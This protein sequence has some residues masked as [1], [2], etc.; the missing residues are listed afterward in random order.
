MKKYII[1]IDTGGT[2][3]DAVVMEKE[4]GRIIQISKTPTTHHLLSQGIARALKDI[5]DLSNITPQAIEKVAISSTLATN[6]VV[7]K[8]GARVAVLVIGYV[9]HFKLPVQA[10]LFIKGGHTITGAEEE[11]LDLDYLVSLLGN[12]EDEVDAFG[13]CSSMSFKNPAH[14]LVTEKA[15]GMIAP[16]PVF[17]SHRI[18]QQAG[19]QERA[20]TAGLHAKLMPLMQEF[21]A[22]VKEAMQKQK[23]SCPIEII[24]GNAQPIDSRKAIEYAGMTV[25]SG[26][27]CTALFGSQHAEPH[28]LIIDVGGT[29][30]DITMIEN[31]QPLFTEEGCNIEDWKT[32]VEAV[33]MHT[34]GIGGD[35][36][37]ILDEKNRITIGPRRVTPISTSGCKAELSVWL[38]RSKQS[39][40]IELITV[41]TDEHSP[42]EILLTLQNH[43]PCTLATLQKS[44]GISGIPLEKQLENLSRHQ[45]IQETGF[46]PTDALHVLGKIEL[47]DTSKAEAAAAILGEYL[48]LSG[49]DFARVVVDK[50][51]EQIENSILDFVT[52]HYWQKS[53]VNF[54]STRH[55]HPVLGVNFSLKIPL[56][57]IGAAAQHFLP[58]IAKRLSTKVHFPDNYHVG[59]AIGAALIVN[60]EDNNPI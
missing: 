53:L 36:H 34:R 46:T 8:K 13:V 52:S 54:I 10:V 58:K 35:S 48:Q 21:M 3:T 4:S 6:A 45:L 24:G 50:T 32:H 38:G 30:T 44:T 56:I 22:G 11:P 9:K 37:V 12:L 60:N 33:N 20:A 26:P 39:K 7:E 47:G 28:A 19:M 23:I 2:F 43:G 25:A 55:D 14:E 1:G 31:G 59:N 57:G 15:I 42:N 49:V 16:K 29:T 41:P 51:A 17:C 18:S 40:C 5:I 27:A